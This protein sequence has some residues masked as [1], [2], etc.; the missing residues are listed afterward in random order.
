MY[1]V[2]GLTHHIVEISGDVTDAGRMDKRED[3]ISFWSVKHWVSQYCF[4]LQQPLCLFFLMIMLQ[5]QPF[6]INESGCAFLSWSILLPRQFVCHSFYNLFLS[7]TIYF[8]RS[9]W[10]CIWCQNCWWLMLKWVWFN[11]WWTWILRM[12]SMMRGN[13]STEKSPAANCV[14]SQL[15]GWTRLSETASS[16]LPGQ[17]SWDGGWGGEKRVGEGKAEAK[18]WLKWLTDGDLV[19]H[20]MWHL[21]SSKAGYCGRHIRQGCLQVDQRLKR[22]FLTKLSFLGFFLSGLPRW[23]GA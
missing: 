7:L 20:R 21:Y 11:D 3:G 16:H 10:T 2:Y 12:Y 18:Q 5:L 13:L 4:C 15:R 22:R 9:I 8:P 23:V 1:G 14:H 19:I 6:V 17:S